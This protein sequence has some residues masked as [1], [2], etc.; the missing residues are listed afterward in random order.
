[1][2]QKQIKISKKLDGFRLDIALVNA[3]IGMSRRKIRRII[4]IG[5]VYINNK[6]VRVASRV[7]HAGDSVRLEFQEEQ[8]KKLKPTNFVLQASDVL[9]DNEHVVV[10]N[11]PAGLPSQATRDQSILHVVPVIEAYYKQQGLKPPAL[12]L[13]HRLDKETSG[14][15][16]CAKS[17][18]AAT[19]LTDQ[20]REKEVE[21]EYTAICYGASRR[22]PFE[23]ACFL[24]AIQS[25]TGIVKQVRSGGKHSHTKF[26]PTAV[27]AKLGLTLMQCFPSTGRSHQLRVHL[28]ANDLPI[29]GDKKY[30]EAK[31]KQLSPALGELGAEHHLLHCRKMVF[32]CSPSERPITVEANMPQTMAKFVELA[33]ADEK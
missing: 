3:D 33:F 28:D 12:T 21:K 8:V 5:G 10:I 25:Q 29:V 19:F 22:E 13:V 18:V 30:G 15:I 17:A 16:I 2:K 23:F 1:M 20:F 4:D 27:N 32:R 31:R 9:L 24:S 14:A 7:V 6:R 11:K 26:V